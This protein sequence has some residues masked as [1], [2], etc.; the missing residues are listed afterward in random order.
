VGKRRGGKILPTGVVKKQ[1]KPEEEEE[2]GVL[3]SHFKI[4]FKVNHIFVS[5]GK[6]RLVTVFERGQEVQR[7]TR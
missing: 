7:T 2:E 1:R 6:R 5:I 4:V 3:K